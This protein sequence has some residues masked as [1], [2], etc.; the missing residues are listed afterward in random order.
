MYVCAHRYIVIFVYVDRTHPS[1]RDASH[2]DFGMLV[3]LLAR[4][5]PELTDDVPVRAF[6]TEH[7]L[8]NNEALETYAGILSTSGT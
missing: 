7:V 6:T 5:D 3:L 2:I 4:T 1:E 8:V